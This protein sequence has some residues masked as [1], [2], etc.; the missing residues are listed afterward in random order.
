MYDWAGCAQRYNS[1][2]IVYRSCE[3]VPMSMIGMGGLEGRRWPCGACFREG[4]RPGG[5]A[6]GLESYLLQGVGEEPALELDA[7]LGGPC[8]P[9]YAISRKTKWTCR[10]SQRKTARRG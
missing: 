4:E 10:R 3:A 6:Q 1:S 7:G 5:Y 9:P 8:S 2:A